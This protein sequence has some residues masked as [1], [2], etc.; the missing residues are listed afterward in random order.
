MAA[1]TNSLGVSLPA[2]TWILDDLTSPY[3]DREGKYQHANSDARSPSR[4]MAV[5]YTSRMLATP[6]ADKASQSRRFRF[7]MHRNLS[8]N[9]LKN[10][11]FC[12]GVGSSLTSRL[13]IDSRLLFGG[14]LELGRFERSGMWHP[15]GAVADRA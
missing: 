3:S 15:D 11:D 9:G 5:K 14:P 6:E 1:W 12:M 10:S 2:V 13:V 8:P 4:L 7:L